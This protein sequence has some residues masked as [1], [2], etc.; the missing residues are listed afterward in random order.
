MSVRF[1]PAA[2]LALLAAPLLL[3]GVA[4]A[5]A[6]REAAPS[7]RAPGAKAAPTAAAELDRKIMAEVADHPQIM[8]NLQYLS[9]VIGPRLT[10]SANLERA[11]RWTAEKMKEYGLENVRLE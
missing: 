9:D 3:G 8:T 4:L 5:E 7:P 6:P 1:R 10:G 11:N 2:R